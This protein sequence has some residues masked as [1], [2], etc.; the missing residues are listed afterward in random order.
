[1]IEYGPIRSG[2]QRRSDPTME[3]DNVSPASLALVT[4][5]H[6]RPHA[7]QQTGEVTRGLG[8]EGRVRQQTGYPEAEAGR[9]GGAG[10][11]YGGVDVEIG[12]RA[13]SGNKPREVHRRL[14]SRDSCARGDGS[15]RSG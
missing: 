6:N 8:R 13:E 5:M 4:I 14:G 11:R 7:G 3:C 15:T 2:S 9:G 10:S 1:M 12:A